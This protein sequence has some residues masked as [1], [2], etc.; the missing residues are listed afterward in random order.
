M[1]NLKLE[2]EAIIISNYCHIIS[3]IL[4][5]HRELSIIKLVFFAF[6]ISTKKEYLNSIYTAKNKKFL[7]D[8]VTSLIVGN[9]DKFCSNI[10]F[11]LK[12]LHLLII[13]KNCKYEDSIV[14]FLTRNGYEKP[15][16]D[17][18]SFIYNAI[19]YCKNVEDFQILKEIVQNV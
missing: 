2:S 5:L 13:N 10:D 15:I 12:A 1:R 14:F 19:E 17:E 4:F 18:Q 7:D 11:I 6:V 9:Y 16:Y 8:K 3:Q